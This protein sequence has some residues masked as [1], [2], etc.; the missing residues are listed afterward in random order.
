MKR[1]FGILMII[2]MLVSSTAMAE[3]WICPG[4]GAEATGNFCSECGTKRPEVEYWICPNCGNIANGNFCTECGMARTQYSPMYEGDTDTRPYRGFDTV[5]TYRIGQYLWDVPT[6]WE[7]ESEQSTAFYAYED[8]G[9]KGAAL[10]LQSIPA[11]DDTA[12]LDYLLSEKGADTEI[13]DLLRILGAGNYE[14]LDTELVSGTG[15]D[16]VL[17][18]VRTTLSGV[19]AI[20]CV[21]MLPAEYDELVFAM[22]LYTDGSAYR[23]DADFREMAYTIQRDASAYVRATAVPTARPTAL[24]S[25]MVQVKLSTGR[26]V[27]IRKSLKEALDEYEEFV[28]SYAESMESLNAWDIMTYL[29]LSS[30]Y[31]EYTQQIAALEDQ[32]TADEKLYYYQVLSAMN[33]LVE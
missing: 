1:L 25:N 10:V 29:S 2:V 31:E 7:Q 17:W 15:Y 16:G 9:S 6:Y 33:E 27:T 23:Y 26:T 21:F 11:D 4:C 18:E 24:P 13:P 8:N 12:T 30:Q 19:G 3:G 28:Y 20:V 22:C 5:Y 32:L 14:L